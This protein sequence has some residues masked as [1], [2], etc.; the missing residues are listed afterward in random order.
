MPWVEIS[1]LVAAYALGS[2]SFG[3]VLAA[4][5]GIDLRTVGSGN[6]GATNAGRALGKREGRVVLVLDAAK[7]VVPALVAA[8]WLGRQSPWTAS[9]AAAAVV[10]HC[11][12]VWHGFRGGKG[13]ATAAGAMLVLSWIAGLAAIATYLVGK[14]A[15]R[16]VSVGSLS[17]AAIGALV[18][19]GLEPARAPAWGA[20]AIALVVW[21]RHADNLARLRRGEEPDG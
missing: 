12:P 20:V 1:L 4:R 6:T 10:G 9:I 11:W 5:R 14:R 19:F 13:A 18:A 15:S 3:L 2:I 8:W 17:G 16:K 21:V 7:G